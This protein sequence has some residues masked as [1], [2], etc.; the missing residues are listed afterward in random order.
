[1]KFLTFSIFVGVRC[2]DFDGVK[3][4]L[5]NKWLNINLDNLEMTVYESYAANGEFLWIYDR[6]KTVFRVL[7]KTV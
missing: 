4:A 7:E 2:L 1:M 3:R 6:L 5:H